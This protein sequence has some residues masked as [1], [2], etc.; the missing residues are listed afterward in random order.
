M[1][2]FKIKSRGCKLGKCIILVLGVKGITDGTVITNRGFSLADHQAS[3]FLLIRSMS[4]VHFTL[5]NNN[6]QFLW[7]LTYLCSIFTVSETYTIHTAAFWNRFISKSHWEGLE[8]YKIW[9]NYIH[10]QSEYFHILKLIRPSWNLNKIL[11]KLRHET[12]Y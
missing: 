5:N 2:N 8:I 7:Q 1:P 3:V 10:I 12:C 11:T 6:F 4:N 9:S